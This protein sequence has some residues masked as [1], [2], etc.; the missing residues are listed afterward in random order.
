MTLI[1]RA[2]PGGQSKLI[3]EGFERLEPVTA[4]VAGHRYSLQERRLHQASVKKPMCT[5]NKPT[6]SLPTIHS[7]IGC[8]AAGSRTSG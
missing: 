8:S 7:T 3:A 1:Q 2:Q 5:K 6:N 4:E